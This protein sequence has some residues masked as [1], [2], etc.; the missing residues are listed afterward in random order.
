MARHRPNPQHKPSKVGACFDTCDA[1]PEMLA[2]AAVGDYQV[3]GAMLV[4]RQLNHAFRKAVDQC[5]KEWCQAYTVLKKA[6]VEAWTCQRVSDYYKAG[7]A[8]ERMFFRAFGGGRHSVQATGLM[9]SKYTPR[10]YEDILRKRC[11]LCNHTIKPC[12]SYSAGLTTGNDMTRG[13]SRSYTFSCKRCEEKYVRALTDDDLVGKP[14]M[15]ANKV[16]NYNHGV[17]DD[18]MLAVLHFVEPIK[19]LQQLHSNT[20]AF[21]QLLSNRAY[22]AVTPDSND[23]DDVRRWIEPHP[24]VEDEDT[25]FGAEGITKRMVEDASDKAVSRMVDVRRAADRRKQRLIQDSNDQKSG[26]RGQ[27]CLQFAM[28]KLPWHTATDMARFSPYML[29]AINYD[30]FV[31]QNISTPQ[32]V[33]HRASYIS[34]VLVANRDPR[35]NKL[36]QSTVDFFLKDQGDSSGSTLIPEPKS[37]WAYRGTAWRG[38][39]QYLRK[40]VWYV[41]NFCHLNFDVHFER[42][43]ESVE[44]DMADTWES[45]MAIYNSGGSTT[46]FTLRMTFPGMQDPQASTGASFSDG[47]LYRM[48]A[49]CDSEAGGDLERVLVR[50]PCARALEDTVTQIL[51]DALK[52]SE[53]HEVLEKMGLDRTILNYVQN[54]VEYGVE[55]GQM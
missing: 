9:I 17:L 44:A 30:S 37:D 31:E 34:D 22:G 6:V 20:S 7:L 46:T 11:S 27:L 43:E 50:E 52:T 8:A 14:S 16:I 36:S 5:I 32:R 47:W 41:E 54:G 49:I 45:Q 40:L 13:D 24:L 23:I 4:M 39:V 25:L 28:A 2:A 51:C 29:K 15:S 21:T 10:V 19:T 48:N 26:R 53:R 38:N 1:L 18:R 35:A 42:R 33:V 3:A 12:V 55:Y